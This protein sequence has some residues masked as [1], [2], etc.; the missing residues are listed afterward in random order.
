LVI[1]F[2]IE[3][4]V[5]GEYLLNQAINK[6]ETDAFIQQQIVNPFNRLSVIQQKIR[7]NHLS[8]Y[9][10]RYESRIYLFDNRGQAVGEDHVKNLAA[11]IQDFTPLAESTNYKGIYLIRNPGN[12]LLKRYLAVIPIKYHVSGYIV[13]DMT[14]RQVLPV[15]VFPKLLL[16][17]RFDEY[18]NQRKY[19]FAIFNKGSVTNAAGEF[20]YKQTRLD[21]E[22][23]NPR[24]YHHELKINDYRHIGIEDIGSQVAIISAPLYSLFNVISNF[25]FYFLA[26]LFTVLIGLGASSIPSIRRRTLSYSNQIQLYVYL[27]MVLPLLALA[28]TIL[29]INAVSEEQHLEEHYED[30]AR[31]MSVNLARM[32]S[33]STG[34]LQDKI[35]EQAQSAGADATLFSTTGAMVASSQP[36]IF[37]NQLTSR[38]VAPEA[39]EEIAKG[40]SLFIRSEVIGKLKF[41]TAYAVVKSTVNDKITGIVSIPF[42]ESQELKE[43]DEIRLV[44]NILGVFVF[45]LLLFYPL[46]FIALSWLTS[47]LRVMAA[48][49]Q[50]TTLSGVNRKLTWKSKDEIG[51]MVKEYNRMIDNLVKS[52]EE[53]E[54]RQRE[55]TWREMARQVAHEIKN[56]LTP[57]RL[58]LQ[59]LE[60]SF[61]EG[62]G[63]QEKTIQSVKTVL[64][65]V[66]I[67]NEIASSFSA[68]AQ[69]P[70]LK[71]ERLNIV[72]VVG[73]AV[74]LHDNPS[75]NKIQL[76]T[77]PVPVWVMVDRKLFSRIFSNIILNAFQ[78]AKE[79]EEIV[80]K[81][82][83]QVKDNVCLLT[84]S[85]N[86]LGM[87]QEVLDKIFIPYFSTKETG[88]GLG[89]A[90]A[91]QG[92][93]QAGGKIWCESIPGIGSTFCISLPLSP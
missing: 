75:K 9:L 82:K 62:R 29:R 84:F 92:I 49:L 52:R 17:S 21:R 2:L 45:V 83:V 35:I 54:K 25:S 22:L 14:L 63:D 50:R 20:N 55:T 48:S 57:I 76:E 15:S 5:L 41:R 56:P 16:D 18:A 91:K 42:F 59:H 87:K 68:F 61:I 90:I 74:D 10:N 51:S 64:H 93:E 38:L 81:I 27:A 78:A 13:L 46:S 69:M 70:E 65:Q 43:K 7:H 26:G 40:K 88:S 19:S 71:L 72:D 86:G 24:L 12:Q 1:L 6:I 31:N 28:I 4:D 53:L 3:R 33:D 39:L 77:S 30:Q 32:L 79:A 73:E 44:S 23:T 58:T 67:L 8:A 11:L 37:S 36:D 89:L 34:N 47:P 66:D 80:I 60:R 85:D